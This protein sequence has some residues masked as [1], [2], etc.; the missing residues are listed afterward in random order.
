MSRRS[1][2]PEGALAV[3]AGLVVNGA[4]AYGFL[5]LTA[6]ALSP[7]DYSSLSVLWAVSFTIGPGLFFPLEQELARVVAARREHGLGASGVVRQAA[8]AG[9]VFVV[10]LIAAAVA[11]RGLLIDRLFT[12]YATLALALVLSFVSFFVLHVIRGVLS[13]SRS[14]VSYGVVSAGEGLARMGVCVVLYLVGSNAPGPYG[15]ALTLAP[16]VALLVFIRR[17]RFVDGGPTIEWVKLGEQ[18]G[19]LLVGRSFLCCS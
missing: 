3:G 4:M 18:I 12:D 10:L 14:F 19:F 5:L 6:R 2:L 9:G 16:L 11:V 7:A 17:V 1:P 13:G 8:L 15:I